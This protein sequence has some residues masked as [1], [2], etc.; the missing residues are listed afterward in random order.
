MGWRIFKTRMQFQ[1]ELKAQGQLAFHPSVNGQKSVRARVM[2][3]CRPNFSP[4]LE[5][6]HRTRGQYAV[7]VHYKNVFHAA[8]T[9]IKMMEYSLYR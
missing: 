6:I 7:H 2:G 5:P 1:A 3:R 4:K 9:I 8:Y